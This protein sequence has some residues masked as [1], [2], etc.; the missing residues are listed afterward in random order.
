MEQASYKMIIAWLDSRKR[1]EVHRN[2]IQI[3]INN[4]AFLLT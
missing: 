1:F 3:I 4:Y 2:P